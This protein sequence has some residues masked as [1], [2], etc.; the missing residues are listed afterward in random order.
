MVWIWTAESFL[1]VFFSEM[2]VAAFPYVFSDFKVFEKYSDL[3]K[4]R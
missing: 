2:Q 4:N 1:I 3:E